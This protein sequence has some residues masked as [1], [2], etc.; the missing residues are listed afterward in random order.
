MKNFKD[1]GIEWLGEI[2]QHWEVKSL[3]CF[4]YLVTD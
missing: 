1:S 4:L 2:P 3:K